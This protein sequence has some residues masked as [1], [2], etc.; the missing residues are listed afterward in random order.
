[1]K[2]ENAKENKRMGKRKMGWIIALGIVVVLGLAGTIGWSFLNKEHDEAKNLPIADVDFKTLR[3]G[4]YTGKYEGG[5]YKW[6]ANEAR[7]TVTSG[8]VKDIELL[9]S[10]DPGKAN[11]QAD[12]LYDSIIKKQSLEVDTLSGATLTCKAYLKAVENALL[13]AE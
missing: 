8:K 6:R 3:D 12:T 11:T 13:Q 10:S 9:E 4:V 5:M 1:M 2:K 7:V